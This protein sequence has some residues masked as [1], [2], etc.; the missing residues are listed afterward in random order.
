MAHLSESELEIIKANPIKDE[1]EVLLSIFKSRYP[2]VNS[3]AAL[4]KLINDPGRCNTEFFRSFDLA[5]L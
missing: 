3:S 4:E 2:N 1:F 5:N